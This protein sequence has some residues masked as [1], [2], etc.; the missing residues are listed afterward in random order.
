MGDF[1]GRAILD[2]AAVGALIGAALAAY[3]IIYGG[4]VKAA[5]FLSSARLRRKAKMTASQEPDS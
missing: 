4:W 3:T 2:A 5:E 1:I